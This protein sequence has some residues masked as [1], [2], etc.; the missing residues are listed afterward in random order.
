MRKWSSR[1]VRCLSRSKAA[2]GELFNDDR[3]KSTGMKDLDEI[4]KDPRVRVRRKGSPESEG[5]CVIYWMQRAQRGV[6]NPGLNV[7]VEVGNALGKPVVVFFA[8]VPF[9]PH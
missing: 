3:L 8:P 6:D 4:L 2:G 1:N 5:T 7:A 9:Y